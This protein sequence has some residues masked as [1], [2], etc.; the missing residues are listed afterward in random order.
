MGHNPA[1]NIKIYISSGLDAQCK[2]WRLFADVLN[3]IAILT[4]LTLLPLYPALSLRILCVTTSMKAM[5]GV[6]GGATRAAITQHQV[7]GFF[8]AFVSF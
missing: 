5:V 4:E 3:D 7:L 8:N 6:A 1:E 2:K